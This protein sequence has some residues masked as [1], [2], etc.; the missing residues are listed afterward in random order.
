MRPDEYNRHHRTT[1]GIVA[2]HSII[3][4]IKPSYV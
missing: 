2:A 4:D 1:N 3:A